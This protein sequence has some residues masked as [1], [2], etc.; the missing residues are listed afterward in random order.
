MDEKGRLKLPVGFQRYLGALPEKG[1]YVTS[2][3]RRT[4]TVYPNAIWRENEKLLA[5]LKQDPKIPKR[6]Q[7]TTQDLG[8]DSEMDNQ[9]RVQFSPELRRYLNIENQPVKVMAT[10]S[11]AIQVMSETVYQKWVAE[12]EATPEDDLAYLESFGFK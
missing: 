12:T 1:L 3:D 7:F 2:T 11:G 4:A 10:P 8:S 6:V 5:T 9:G